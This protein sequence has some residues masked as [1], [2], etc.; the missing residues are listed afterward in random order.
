MALHLE[1]LL[2]EMTGGA[3]GVLVEKWPAIKGYAEPEFKK[4]A[5]NLIKIEAL[6]LE[7]KLTEEK[8]KLQFEMQTN[9]AKSVLLTV[10]GL[11]KL[12]VE[13]MI[14]AALS[15]IKAPVNKAIG[16]GLL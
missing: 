3:K 10:E 11:G 9:A 7:G 15:A 14:N 13:Q 2:K 4:I 6:K 1:D 16:F 12:V 8:A 5:Q